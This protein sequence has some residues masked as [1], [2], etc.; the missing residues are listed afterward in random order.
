MKGF[1]EGVRRMTEI[2]IF[3]ASALGSMC[4]IALLVVMDKFR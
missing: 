3:F 2:S 1:G 4:G